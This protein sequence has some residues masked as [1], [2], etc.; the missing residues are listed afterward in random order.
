[1][2]RLKR[3]LIFCLAL[4]AIFDIAA[5]TDTVIAVADTADAS[6]RAEIIKPRRTIFQKLI[7]YISESN[8]KQPAK[9]FDFSILGGPYY[10]Q[11]TNFGIGLVAA[12]TFRRNLADTVAP[13]TQ[14]SLYGD[15]SVTGY[16]K[17]G[18]D[19]SSYFKGDRVWLYYDLYFYSRPDRYWGIG[20]DSNVNDDNMVKYKRWKARLHAATLFQV[21]N[22]NL[23]VGPVLQLDYV[24]AKTQPDPQLWRGQKR[25][26]FTDAVGL[27]IVYD[28]RDDVYN[29]Y[30]GVYARIEQLF[31]PRFIGNQYDFILTEGDFRWY[32]Q[33]WKGGVLASQMHARLTFGNTPWG[34]MSEIGGSNSMRGYWEGRYND[35]CAA[36]FTLELRQ[37]LFKR[38]GFVVWGGV[39]EVFPRVNDM[40][41]GHALWN[42]G[43][44]LRWEFKHRV[45]VRVDY[46][47]GQGQSGLEF[48]INE[49]F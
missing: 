15:V 31:A 45:N 22:P 5:Q 26:T 16:F 28:T 13:P 18:V 46:G 33:L 12:G 2:A 37:H 39:G 24:D 20:Y 11:D 7:D 43:V 3:H 40:F 4:C 25:R 32:K 36:D 47:F 35:K 30:R 14:F 8:R 9:K 34:E 10:S 21:L 23:Y 19:G 29:A 42:A 6:S 41:K 48:S 44:G 38:F 49:A 1:M 17:V 27:S